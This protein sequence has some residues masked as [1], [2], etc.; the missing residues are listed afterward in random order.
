M[1]PVPVPRPDPRDNV[2]ITRHAYGLAAFHGDA[3][4]REVPKT[5]RR[6]ALLLLVL[7]V[8]IPAFLAGLLIVL[9]HMAG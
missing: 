7:A 1:E 4:L 8:T 5:L 6:V 9:W 2:S 3:I